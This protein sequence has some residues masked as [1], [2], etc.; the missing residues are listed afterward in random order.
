MRRDNLRDEEAV[1]LIKAFAAIGDSDVRHG[2]IAVAE[3]AALGENQHAE[4]E[5]PE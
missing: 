3:A 1:R 2:L 4:E 5:P